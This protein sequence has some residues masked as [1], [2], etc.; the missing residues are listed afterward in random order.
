MQVEIASQCIRALD[1]VGEIMITTL[2]VYEDYNDG[3][4]IY[5][6]IRVREN[7]IRP[8]TPPGMKDFI[9]RI[10][11]REKLNKEPTLLCE[12]TILEDSKEN[13]TNEPQTHSVKEAF[14]EIPEK[15]TGNHFPSSFYCT[16]YLQKYS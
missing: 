4:P 13:I 8:K 6:P 14:H 5:K 1:A 10:Q 15:P 9:L 11:E 16:T 3:V 2:L 12:E 7:F